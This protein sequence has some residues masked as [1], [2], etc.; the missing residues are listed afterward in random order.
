MR[1][2]GAI[3]AS[4]TTVGVLLLTGCSSSLDGAKMEDEITSQITEQVGGE[5]TVTCPES[6][7]VKA[8]GTFTCTATDASGATETINVTQSDDQGN[9]TWEIPAT[10]LDLE[11]LKTGVA[12][13]LA[14]QVGGE[15]TVDCPDDIPIEKGLTAN[16]EATSADGQSTMIN[17]T[18]TDDQGNV[19]WETAE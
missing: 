1:R 18:Q 14:K 19:T 12:A 2:S 7:P 13:E 17:V 3:A 4:L 6:E 16:C 9:I 11:A 15:W 5:W 8:G 10:G